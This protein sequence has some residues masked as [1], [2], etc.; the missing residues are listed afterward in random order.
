MWRD[1]QVN[2]LIKTPYFLKT[3][4]A[5]FSPKKDKAKR[6]EQH[7]EYMFVL[8][9]GTPSAFNPIMINSKRAGWTNGTSTFRANGDC[10]VES[11]RHKP[12]AEKKKAG[13]VWSYAIG[14][15]SS[16]DVHAS[17]HPAIFPEQLAHD[18]IISWS[19]EGDTVLDPFMGSGTTGKMATQLGREFIGI[20]M[21][22][23]YFN[24][25]Q[26]RIEKAHKDKAQAQWGK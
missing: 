5:V 24:I 12:I 10:L 13:N 7:A 15:R 26:E 19:N 18:H 3:A 1:L 20:E 21:D 9:K 16:T 11:K 25:A 6:Y 2:L 22:D 4:A 17:N 14:R 23:E 8:A